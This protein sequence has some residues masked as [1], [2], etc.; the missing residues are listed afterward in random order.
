MGD[1]PVSFMTDPNLIVKTFMCI[2]QTPKLVQLSKKQ[3]VV[4][5]ERIDHE[6]TVK[7]ECGKMSEEE[8]QLK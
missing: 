5:F 2:L 3:I 6:S 4:T 7:I 8:P 1:Q